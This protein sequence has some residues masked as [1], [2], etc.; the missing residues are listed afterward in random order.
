MS[1]SDSNFV[2][3][4]ALAVAAL[5]L[6][7]A[8]RADDPHSGERPYEMAGR[9]PAHPP[10]VDFEDLSGWTVIGHLG[11][12]GAIEASREQ[13]L[14]GEYV[15]KVTYR[16]TRPESRLE[17]R[18]PAPIPIPGEFDAACIWTYGDNWGWMPAPTRPSVHA[19]IEDAAGVEHEVGFG[20]VD[21]RYWF[22]AHTRIRLQAAHA[23]ESPA[24]KFPAKLKSLII[25]DLKRDEPSAIYLDNLTFY[26]EPLEPIA[27]PPPGPNPFPTTPDTILPTVYDAVANTLEQRDGVWVWRCASPQGTLEY[28]WRPGEGTLGDIEACWGD[29][30]FRPCAEG[31]PLFEVNGVEMRPDDAAV[32]RSVVSAE[33]DGD[34]V[35]AKW[36][37][38]KDGASA[39]WTLTLRAKQR[40][41]ILDVAAPD[42]KAAAI[43][44]GH[45][46]GTPQPK[47][48]SVPYLTYGDRGPYV[49]CS[50]GLFVSAMFDWYS[51]DASALFADG[52]ILSD[53]AARYTGGARYRPKT[54]GT[55]NEARERVFL[56]VSPDFRE[57]LPNIPNPR[58]DTIDVARH[59]LW[60]NIG[61]MSPDMLKEYA[62]YGIDGFMACHHEII[63][64]DGGES[65]TQRLESAPTNVGDERL[66]EYM[67]MIKSLGFL[68]GLYT[69]Y[70]DFAPVS[71]QWDPDKVTRLPDGSW[72]RA[73]PRNYVFKPCFADDAEA[74][75][76]PRI[77][78]KF[79][80]YAGYCDVHTA[81]TPWD[82]TDY[83][84]RV[85]GAGMFRP[86]FES[87]GRLLFNESLAHHGP[88]F[89]EGRNHW[90][91]AGLVDG[92]YAQ[93]VSPN[94]AR[95][96][97]LVDFDL[98]KLHPLETDFG[99]GS[100]DM[101]YR[102]EEWTKDRTAH[103]PYLDRFIASTIAY[104]HIGYLTA[105]WG[106]P[107]TLKS[108]YLLRALQELYAGVEVEGI[109]YN[110]DGDLLTTSEAVAND[111]Y[112]DGQVH[113]RY[114]N[115]LEVWAN[116]SWDRDWALEVDGQRY[117][118]PP[119]GFVCRMPGRLLEY[120]AVVDGARRE[121]VECADYVYLDTRGESLKAGP[122]E[123]R[124]AA[125][126]K[127]APEGLWVI[128]ATE[129]EALTIFPNDG[130]WGLAWPADAIA[131]TAYSV[132]GE[133]VGAAECRPTRGGVA[134]MPVAGAI[135]YLL[136]CEQ[137]EA[138]GVSVEL[139]ASPQAR[140]V[141]AGEALNPVVQGCDL[142]KWGFER[143]TPLP[144]RERLAR[145][146][147]DKGEG[148]LPGY[149]PS[150]G[151]PAAGRPLTP[152]VYPPLVGGQVPARERCCHRTH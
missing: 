85:P 140:E 59:H 143:R 55:R 80:T 3:A 2:A 133:N 20:M 9:Q 75:F 48:V 70:R 17:I 98:L 61:F 5:C 101:F 44:V 91:Y 147:R 117:L 125:A 31:G 138:Q 69:N 57:V 103:S 94:P 50:D 63:W 7:C 19:V 10:L 88:V 141:A 92:N 121:Y 106:M 151:P 124:G 35:R 51:S 122:V 130:P 111:V 13:Q 87:Y 46:E 93:I 26:R 148:R 21:A 74:Y 145:H 109:A 104:G 120:S 54:D 22:L 4:L 39:E 6:A 62:A 58:S 56:T 134:V 129:C 41:L 150:P 8:A 77:H 29:R 114:R 42:G 86:A 142:E 60:R 68:P 149:S 84:A 38:A 119:T 132:T 23:A 1:P 71:K 78:D 36:R 116:C 100:P 72:Q 152:E 136:T 76:A 18:P 83:D 12:E 127:Q 40:S 115:G 82:Q 113:V 32:T 144:T 123:G 52:A 99:M 11:G 131:A 67:A 97:L 15:G 139:I 90:F 107:G 25:T 43:L 112:R 28:S 16:G 79:G 118:L 95:E 65:F 89:S 53:T 146:R 137:Q 66:R 64:R 24:I 27:A 49:L 33:R 81:V 128:P 108:F 110:S 37:W 73:W 135:K 96:P 47:L 45:S 34:A 14:W 102:D 105:E 30:R 126:I